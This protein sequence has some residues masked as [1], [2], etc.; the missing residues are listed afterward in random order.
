MKNMEVYLWHN[1]RGGRWGKKSRRKER[2]GREN[3]KKATK[4]SRENK[5]TFKKSCCFTL[6]HL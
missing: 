2:E 1:L 5:K 4:S 6:M 3:F